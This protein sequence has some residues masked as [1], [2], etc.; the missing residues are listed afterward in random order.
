[1]IESSDLRRRN[2]SMRFSPAERILMTVFLWMAVVGLAA[3]LIIYLPT[4]H[5]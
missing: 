2:R 1:M 3:L 4:A 5:P